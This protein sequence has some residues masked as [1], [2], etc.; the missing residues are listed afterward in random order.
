MAIL[1]EFRN[2]FVTWKKRSEQDIKYIVWVHKAKLIVIEFLKHWFFFSLNSLVR[3][4]SSPLV[5]FV[6][7][8]TH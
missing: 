3:L 1:M 5:R 7:F 8:G 4:L 6:K 2:F